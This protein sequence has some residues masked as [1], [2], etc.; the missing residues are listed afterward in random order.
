LGFALLME[1][2]NVPIYVPFFLF[3]IA[4]TAWYGGSGAAALGLLLSSLS[5]DYFFIEPNYSFYKS[6]SGLPNFIVFALFA[7]LVTWL[8][9]V[10]RRVELELRQARD[11]LEIEV[12]ERTQQASLLNLTHDSI[13]VRDMNDVITFW[14]RGAQEL[15]GWTAEEAIGK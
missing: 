10:R 5:F 11:V 12:A 13:F 7:S 2:L 8:S 4:V 14:N 9:A 15:Y 1:R 3:A 6:R